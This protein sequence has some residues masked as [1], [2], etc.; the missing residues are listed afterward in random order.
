M[1]ATLT[2][3]L[4]LFVVLMCLR[5]PIAFSMIGASALYLILKGIPL[6]V[7][8]HII[9]F[10][11]ADSYVLLAVPLFMLAGS[12]M[13]VSGISDKIFAFALALV[14]RMPGSL[15]HVNVI[16]S[17]IFSGTSGSALADIGGLGVMQIDSMTKAGYTK[18]FA[19]ATTVAS[20]TIGPIFPPSIP[21]VVLA[22]TVELSAVEL[23]VAGIM[24]GLVL[25]IVLMITVAIMAKINNFPRTEKRATF[26]EIWS[27]F[28]RALP[29]ILAPFILIGGMVSGLF[30]P[31]ESAAVVVGYSLFLGFIVYRQLT[32]KLLKEQL[33]NTCYATATILFMVAAATLLSWVLTAEKIPDM[34]AAYLLGITQNRWLLMIFMNIVLL[35]VGC[36]MCNAPAILIFAPIFMPM[37]VKVGFDPIHV[38]LVFVFNLMIGLITPPVGLSLFLVSIVAQEKMGVVLRQ[39][40]PFL[41][42]LFAALILLTFVPEITLFGPKLLIR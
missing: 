15:G 4:I 37:M 30:S 26:G 36:F 13:N 19:A 41:I 3:F 42:A 28:I 23:L 27:S 5:V 33:I 20:A 21:I 40:V 31:T 17:L 2:S 22:A 14:G 29:A 11:I 6:E 9:T 24:P 1:N 35:I 38:G 12:I 32:W 18:A 39:T 25:T 10:T 8:A 16:C 34:L 7:T